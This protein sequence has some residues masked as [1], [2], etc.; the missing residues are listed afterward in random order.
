MLAIYQGDM[1]EFG[2][3]NLLKKYKHI[4]AQI[5]VFPHHGGNSG[6]L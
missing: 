4:E 6:K 3:N 2:L 1:N 5:L